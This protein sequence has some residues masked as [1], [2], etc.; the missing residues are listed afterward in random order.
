MFWR[1]GGVGLTEVTSNDGP[2]AVD[3]PKTA[4]HPMIKAPAVEIACRIPPNDSIGL[5]VEWQPSAG[6]VR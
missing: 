2:A 5:L 3:W 4:A 1:S 6:A